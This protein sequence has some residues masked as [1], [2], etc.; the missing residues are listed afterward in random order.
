MTH[1]LNWLETPPI[2]NPLKTTSHEDSEHII[3]SA[4]L[5]HTEASELKAAIINTINKAV[6]LLPCN[7]E[8]TS[9]YFLFEWDTK[10]CC[11]TVVITDDNK[12]ID[13]RHIVQCNMSGLNRRM[14]ELLSNSKET[15]KNSISELTQ[16]I[17]ESIHNYL[18]TSAGFMRYSLIA[19]F[20]SD[21]RENT[22]LI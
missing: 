8:D 4:S 18:T 21:S 16:E 11:L 17:K 2:T 19:V 3:H 7:M 12:E 14:E 6:E 10:T 22:K 1:Q 13:S 5:V 20:H 9:R 15:L